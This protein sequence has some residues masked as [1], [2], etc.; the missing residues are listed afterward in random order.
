MWF[1]NKN[2][3]FFFFELTLVEER[4]NAGAQGSKNMAH[5]LEQLS[6]KVGVYFSLLSV[7]TFTIICV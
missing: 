3:C 1:I 2:A 4:K 6:F 7:Y 5:W